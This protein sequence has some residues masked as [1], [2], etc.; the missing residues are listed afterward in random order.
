MVKLILFYM[1]IRCVILHLKKRETNG[2]RTLVSSVVVRHLSLCATPRFSKK[3]L[4]K[5]CINNSINF[6]SIFLENGWELDPIPL[7]KYPS[8]RVLYYEIT[9]LKSVIHNSCTPIVREATATVGKYVSGWKGEFP[10]PPPNT[11]WQYT[12]CNKLSVLFNRN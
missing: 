10:A 1:N 8:G 5:G 4:T 6:E 2:N 11:S 9:L 7:L 12:T 3:V